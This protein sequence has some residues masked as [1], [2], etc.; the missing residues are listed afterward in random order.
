MTQV[1]TDMI[2]DQATAQQVEPAP[3]VIPPLP[4]ERTQAMNALIR[5]TQNLINVAEREA[6][7]L[8]LNDLLTF[9]LLQDE[10]ASM[11]D[12]YETYSKQFRKRL[13]EFRGM[14][15]GLLNRLEKLQQ[16]LGEKT[17]TNTKVVEKI[18]GRAQQKAHHSLLAAQELAQTKH[19]SYQAKDGAK[20]NGTQ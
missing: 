20:K 3:R 9:N 5:A 10:K 2:A 7:A 15:R 1:H 16:T 6:Q 14:D 13:N 18:H 12:R 4:T 11:A 19:V 8:A 17:A